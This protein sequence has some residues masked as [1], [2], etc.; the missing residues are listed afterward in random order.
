[1]EVD[2]GG[3]QKRVANRPKAKHIF[4]EP[5][6]DRE[7]L[8]LGI[9]SLWRESPLFFMKGINNVEDIENWVTVAVKLWE[10]PIDISVKIS[11]ASCMRKVSEQTFMTPATDDNYS[12]MV[13]IVKLSL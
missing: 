9:L 7:V 10:A 3:V 1:M 11:T 2:Q 13:D 8:I 6:S 4:P 12:L 5:L